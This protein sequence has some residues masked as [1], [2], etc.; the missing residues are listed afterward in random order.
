VTPRERV[1]AAVE[2][3]EPDVVPYQVSFTQPAFARMVDATGDPDFAAKIGNHLAVAEAEPPDAWTEVRPGYMQ[4]EFGVIWNRTVDPDIGVPYNRVVTEENVS[5]VAFPDPDAAGRCDSV[6]ALARETQRATMVALGFSLFERAW[7]LTG[8]T[9]LLV[10]MATG[11]PLADVLLDRILEWN[12]AVL[13]R[14]LTHDFDIMHFGDDWGQ[15]HGLIMGP[16]HWRRFIRPRVA[17]MY[18]ACRDAGKIVSIHSCGDI[19]EILPDLVEIG[20]NVFNPFQPEVID[21]RWAKRE[22]GDRL[23]FWGGVSTQKTL[24]FGTPEDVVAEVTGL[25]R[26]VGAGGGYICAPAHAIPGDAPAENMQ[27]LIE[28]LKNQ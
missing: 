7:T 20:V 25:L 24:P 27:A 12:L 8:M 28:T 26:D 19:K 5:R 18:A 21:P 2:H 3:R 17:R 9:E 14:V 13:D 16:G 6:A 10:A 11:D 22:F 15:Q 1:L 23:C 4:D